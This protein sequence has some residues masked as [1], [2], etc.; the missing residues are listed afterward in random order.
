MRYDQRCIRV[1]TYLSALW[2]LTLLA[3]VASVA[4]FGQE[5][6]ESLGVTW[7]FAAVNIL[8]TL[9]IIGLI[10]PNIV[11]LASKDKSQGQ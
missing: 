2:L 11:Y 7:L 8:L 9:V 1:A 5:S 6:M 3:A 4:I 10:I